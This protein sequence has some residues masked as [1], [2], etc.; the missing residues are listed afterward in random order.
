MI[1]REYLSAE[2]T[3]QICGDDHWV[4]W[5][6]TDTVTGKRRL[7]TSLETPGDSKVKQSELENTDINA[8]VSKWFK[9]GMPVQGLIQDTRPAY[10]GDFTDAKSFEDHQNDVLEVKQEFMKQPAQVR[11]FFSNS[12]AAMIEWLSHAENYEAAQ[13]MG[14]LPVAEALGDSAE[15]SPAPALRLGS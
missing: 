11:A 10:V 1:E 14:L 8:L 6:E 12:P 3:K 2:E 5:Y 7:R 15:A 13:E 4:A 9:N